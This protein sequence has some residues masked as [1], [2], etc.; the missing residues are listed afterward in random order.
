MA[1]RIRIVE[2][3][4]FGVMY[5]QGKRIRVCRVES[6]CSW[7]CPWYLYNLGRAKALKIR[8]VRERQRR[9]SESSRSGKPT[10]VAAWV[11]AD[12]IR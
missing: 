10:N 7:Y 12:T 2:I 9:D 4:F 5:R 3:R 6:P 11:V 1:G 8:R